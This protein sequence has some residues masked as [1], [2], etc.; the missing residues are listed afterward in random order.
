MDRGPNPRNVMSSTG[1]NTGQPRAIDLAGANRR[2]AGDLVSTF[3]MATPTPPFRAGDEF[4]PRHGTVSG[5]SANTVACTMLTSPEIPSRCNG[6]HQTQIASALGAHQP[7]RIERK[8]AK[9]LCPKYRMTN[10]KDNSF[11]VRR[12]D[13]VERGR[14]SLRRRPQRIITGSTCL[15]T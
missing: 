7:A 15:I 8:G 3:P 12:D 5:T 14:C 4:N 13:T 2:P 11:Q 6:D 1:R 9:T 10:R